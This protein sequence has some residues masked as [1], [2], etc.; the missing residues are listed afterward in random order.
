MYGFFTS[1]I[2]LRRPGGGSSRNSGRPGLAGKGRGGRKP[3]LKPHHFEKRAP[4]ADCQA[5]K[6]LQMPLEAE[7]TAIEEQQA[8]GKTF[9][10]YVIDC[11][12][13]GACTRAA[14]PH[15]LALSI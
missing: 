3:W 11:S 15:S 10:V 6:A 5:S 13:D 8:G 12:D 14:C 7:I 4:I 9:K 1:P 2:Y